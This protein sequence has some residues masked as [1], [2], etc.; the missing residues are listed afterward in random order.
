MIQYEDDLIQ[1]DSLIQKDDLTQ[2]N[3]LTQ[4]D[5]LIQGKLHEY[6]KKKK[7]KAGA[8]GAPKLAQEGFE[9][10]LDGK[11]HHEGA[12]HKDEPEHHEEHY[13]ESLL[14]RFGVI[15]D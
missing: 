15:L 13:G 3:D 4:E 7:P 10:I 8:A 11:E 2:E 5:E 6:Q 9:H 1:E 14:Q 12:I